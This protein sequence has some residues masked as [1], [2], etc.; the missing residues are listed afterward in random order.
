MCESLYFSVYLSHTFLFLHTPLCTQADTH[1]HVFTQIN[2][3]QASPKLQSRLS[4]DVA[5][6]GCEREIFQQNTGEHT[7]KNGDTWRRFPRQVDSTIETC[8][9]VNFCFWVVA[10]VHFL[11][12][13]S[14]SDHT[15]V[16]RIVISERP[17]NL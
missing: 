1:T 8:L 5:G 13:R 4:D 6:I 2:A 11:R 17:T 10:L 12:P 9:L 3:Q 14:P 7:F 15:S 16:P